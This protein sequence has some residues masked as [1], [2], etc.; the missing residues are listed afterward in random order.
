M[1]ADKA[2]KLSASPN[3]S[4]SPPSFLAATDSLI[5]VR[6]AQSR[7]IAGGSAEKKGSDLTQA[8]LSEGMLYAPVYHALKGGHGGPFEVS[9][10]PAGSLKT[11]RRWTFMPLAESYSIFIHLLMCIFWGRDSKKHFYASHSSGGKDHKQPLVCLHAVYCDILIWHCSR[12]GLYP[13]FATVKPS[14]N[15]PGSIRY[16]RHLITNLN[17]RRA[18]T[19]K[20]NEAHRLQPGVLTR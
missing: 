10:H 19:I 4:I 6:K 13:I 18:Q 7:W 17:S 14:P 15:F 2:W 16:Y 3:L 8:G 9:D 5:C 11:C 20:T 1:A 12:V